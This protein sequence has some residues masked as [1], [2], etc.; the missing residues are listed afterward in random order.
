MSYLGA[1]TPF[2]SKAQI[3]CQDPK[4]ILLNTVR[5]VSLNFARTN[6]FSKGFAHIPYDWAPNTVDVQM[7][8]VGNFGMY[9]GIS[10]FPSLM[11]CQFSVMLIMPGMSSASPRCQK[12]SKL[13]DD[14]LP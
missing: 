4:P 2:P 12:M 5:L 1:I 11:R 14:S 7:L 8:R 9:S 10:I 3:A 13:I 6:R